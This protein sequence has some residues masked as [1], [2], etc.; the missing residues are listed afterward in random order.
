MIADALHEGESIVESACVEIVEE[1]SADAAGLRAMFDIEVAVAGLLELG[2]K[3]GSEWIAGGFGGPVPFDGVL[4]KSVV[5]REVETAAEP[6][7]IG[8]VGGA[9][10][11]EEETYVGMRSGRVWI[12]WVDDDRY[13]GGVKW[14]SGELRASCGGG[15]RQLVAHYVGKIDARFFED[16][17]AFEDACDSAASGWAIPSVYD[18]WMVRVFDR[19]KLSA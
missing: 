4:A 19:L 10:R 3:M 9:S 8:F 18:E 5:G 7:H 17:A 12:A 6:P 13:A 14:A 15:G 16:I 11:S 2:I 1:E